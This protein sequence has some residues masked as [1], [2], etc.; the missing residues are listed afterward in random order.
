[1]SPTVLRAGSKTNVIP[2]LAE[3]EIDGRVLPGTTTVEFL[4]ELQAVLGPEFELEVTNAWDPMVTSP[5]ESSF[6][7]CIHALMAER[8]PDAPLVPYLMP[9]FTD[10]TAFTRMG[11]RWYGFAP[12]KLPKGMKFA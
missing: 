4:A 3:V 1:A 10:A 2:S 5:R 7:D 9:G 8:E 11:A 12:V 6:L